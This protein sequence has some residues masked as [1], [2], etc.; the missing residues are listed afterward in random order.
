MPTYLFWYETPGG[1]ETETR[2]FPDD[3]KALEHARKAGRRTMVKVYRDKQLI[4][5]MRTR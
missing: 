3:R 1:D 2:D 4:G 5:Q